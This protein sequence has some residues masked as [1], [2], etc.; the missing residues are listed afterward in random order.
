MELKDFI[1]TY[2]D[3]LDEKS[4]D[5]LIDI[6]NKTE[7]G[8]EH[9]DTEL[10]KFEQL[11]LNECGMS[12]MAKDIAK[13][14]I[15]LFEDYFKQTGVSDYIGIQGFESVRI[16]K[17]LKG[18]GAQFKTH[19]D[20]ADAYS[21]KRYCVAIIYLNDNNGVTEFPLLGYSYKPK[22]GSVI[23]F[24]PTWQYPH[25]GNVP[26]DDDKYIMMTCLTFV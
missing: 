1:I 3:F 12:P 24:P 17:Y 9:H 15:P 18:T 13:G 4:C 26:T 19:I 20:V 10:Y 2:D 22:K 16:K 21:S 23:M 7:E 6:F 25:S 14:L 8:R 5:M 11:N